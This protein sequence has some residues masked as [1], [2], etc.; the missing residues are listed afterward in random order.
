MT[1]SLRV[2]GSEGLESPPHQQENTDHEEEEP[3][4]NAQPMRPTP[5]TLA[6]RARRDNA[7]WLL[8]RRTDNRRPSRGRAESRAIAESIQ[9]WM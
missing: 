9:D 3:Q 2:R 1:L 4:V 6:R 7:D 8:D 5:R